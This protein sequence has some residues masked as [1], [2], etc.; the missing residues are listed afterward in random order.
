MVDCITY[1]SFY[2][3][4]PAKFNEYTLRN[5][6]SIEISQ[7]DKMF[8]TKM[9]SHL[10]IRSEIG[11]ENSAFTKNNLW[12]TMTMQVIVMPFVVWSK[13][14]PAAWLINHVNSIDFVYNGDAWNANKAMINSKTAWNT[15]VHVCI[16]DKLGVQDKQF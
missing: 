15:G 11:S 13:L 16:T 7:N 12:F 4:N 3:E 10:C 1:K 6:D 2:I 14:V 5:H 9:F 8:C